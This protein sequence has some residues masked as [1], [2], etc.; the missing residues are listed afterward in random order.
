MND[1]NDNVLHDKVLNLVGSVSA[2]WTA[3][4]YTENMRDKE[5]LKAESSFRFGPC[6]SGIKQNA[7]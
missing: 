7:T 2:S 1:K 6:A 4:I 5:R 3:R